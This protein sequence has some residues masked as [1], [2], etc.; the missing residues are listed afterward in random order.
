MGRFVLR[1]LLQ[2]IPLL[3]GITLIT[4]ILANAVPGSPVSNIAFNPNVSQEDIERIQGDVA[5]RLVAQARQ[6]GA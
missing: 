3:I 5:E 6:A 4:F 1:R 2:M